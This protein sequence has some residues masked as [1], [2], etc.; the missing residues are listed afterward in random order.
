M[1]TYRYKIEA[2]VLLDVNG[3]ELYFDDDENPT[4][5]LP[6]ERL[7]D[8]FLDSRSIGTEYADIEDIIQVR[9]SF[10]N[11]VNKLN[12]IINEN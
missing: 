3:I 12:G 11:I 6:V 7:V 4:A 10:Q 8:E 5:N 1:V 9:D 2:S